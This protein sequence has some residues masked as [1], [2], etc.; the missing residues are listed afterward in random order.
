MYEHIKYIIE[1]GAMLTKHLCSRKLNGV[2]LGA[3]YSS[4]SQARGM[5]RLYLMLF[6]LR[7]DM[8]MSKNSTEM[9]HD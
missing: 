9:E 3:H 6:L 4:T 7:L 5:N 1:V 2:L 8:I